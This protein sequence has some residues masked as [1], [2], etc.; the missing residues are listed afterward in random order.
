MRTISPELAR[1]YEEHG[2]WTR[3]SLGE[4]LAHGLASAPDTSFRV[5]SDI[6]PY[7][8]TFRE[9]ELVARRLATGLRDRGVG[10]GDVVALQ[11]PNWMEAAAAFWAASLLGTVVVPIVHTYGSREVGHIVETVRPAAFF[12]AE[13]FGNL[14]YDPAVHA[15][16]PVVGIVGGGDPAHRF[17]SLLADEPFAGVAQVDPAGPAVI[18]FTSGTT[19]VPKGVVHSHQTLGCETRLMPQR[20][21]A[22]LG[23][24]INAAPIG[25]FIGMLSALLVPVREGVSI[26]LADVWNPGRI[27]EVMTTYGVSLGGGVPYY[28][29]SLI[30]HPDCTRDQLARLRYLGMG[31][32]PVAAPVAERLTGLGL[33]VYRS[34]GS[35]EHPSMTAAHWT[36]PESKRLYTDGVPQP[37]VE[38]RLAEDGE[39]LSRGPDLCLGYL[40][41]TLTAAA[42]DD[43]GWYHTGDIGTLDA[44][45]YL[46]IVDR[47]TDLIIRGGENISALEV[48]EVLLTVPGVTEAVA[49]AAPD[50]RL[51]EHVAAVLR[52]Q[53]GTAAPSLEDLCAY[54][55]DA[56]L[57]K[58][59]WPQEIHVVDDFPRSPSGKVQKYKIRQSLATNRSEPGAATG[60]E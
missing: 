50:A 7:S 45:G 18:A 42:F 12:G 24:L 32:A 22:D 47:T 5:H 17:E 6:R 49:V 13:R 8:G 38:L 29:T 31:G 1:R 41:D 58:Q 19:R 21:P 33:T 4:L 39:I 26:D 56:G 44:D 11:L 40:D 43:E 53:P 2:W 16:V 57:A 15:S 14:V 55:A 10:P 28:V 35:T 9:V 3:D 36:A 34:Y 27:L 30:D 46:T 25:H 59:K 54:F 23:P 48:E 51:G 52:R 20:Y 60:A 37:G